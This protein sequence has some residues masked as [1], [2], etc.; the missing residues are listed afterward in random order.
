[1]SAERLTKWSRREALGLGLVA[2][3]G[4]AGFGAAL[5][6]GGEQGPVSRAYVLGP[7][8]EVD[9]RLS[10]S[11]V[12]TI[13][14]IKSHLVRYEPNAQ[15]RAM[16]ADSVPGYLLLS[17]KCTH[18]GCKVPRCD[19]SEWFECLCHGVRYNRIGEYQFGPAP[20]GFDRYATRIVAGV[21]LVADTR[22][23]IL[24]PPRGTDTIHQP[25]AGPH[26]VG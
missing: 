20:R 26:C 4:L 22:N 9:R 11:G 14:E 5:Y 12:L 1:M 15:T 2:S 23:R 19:S 13:P 24:G 18:L 3:T 25:P 10:S 6:R 17:W 7:L 16:Y 21:G 8:N